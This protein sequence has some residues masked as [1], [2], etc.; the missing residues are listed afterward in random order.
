MYYQKK[1][2]PST[3]G[4]FTDELGYKIGREQKLK[5]RLVDAIENEELRLVYQPILNTKDR[6][7]FAFEALLRWQLDGEAIAPDEFIG[8]AEQYGQIRKIGTW[9]LRESCLA[10]RRWQLMTDTYNEI[11]VS[12][13]VSVI[14]MQ[15]EKFKDVVKETLSESGLAP[16]CLYLEI[17]ESVFAT[18]IEKLLQQVLA[19]Q[20]MG[21]KVSIDDFGT[22]YSSLAV[23][24]DLAVN[25]VK[26][27]RSF[28]NKVKTNG[29]SIVNAVMNIAGGLHFKVVAEG[30]E[31]LEQMDQLESL[32]VDYLQGFYFSKP[33]EESAISN[34]LKS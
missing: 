5:I 19:L 23:M 10:A 25:L 26:I 8:I 34:Y 15:D 14:Q 1:R 6:A 24:Q 4:I 33:M 12:V 16:H 29:Q 22:G 28:V 20:K 32:G 7:I 21:V 30:V 27:D 13:N 18:D 9:V 3:V 17:T 31:T 2:S 11:A